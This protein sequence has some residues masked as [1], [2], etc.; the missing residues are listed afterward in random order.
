[1]A[2]FKL[3]EREDE[4]ARKF[5]EEHKGCRPDLSHKIFPTYA[6]YTYKFTPTGI[7]SCVS[8]TCP[9]CGEEKDITDVD[10]W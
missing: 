1:M 4:L 6:P 10:S 8:I 9:Y 7:G 3:T 2:S 5:R